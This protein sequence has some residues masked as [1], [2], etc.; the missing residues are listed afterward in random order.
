MKTRAAFTLLELLTIIGIISI[1]AA[2][3]LGAMFQSKVKAQK[4]QCANNLRQQGIALQQFTM[5][6]G[7]YPPDVNPAI[8]SEGRSWRAA[9]QSEIYNTVKI[10]SR[11]RSLWNCPSAAR[12]TSVDWESHEDWVYVDYGYNAYGLG[13][14]ASSNSLGLAKYWFNKQGNFI[15]VSRVGEAQVANPAEM[16]AIGDGFFGC[17]DAIKDGGGNF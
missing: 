8:W 6:N 13:S 5:D 1:G 15:S 16:Y 10:T 14:L 11:S 4:I 7:F 2:L 9:L 3:L 17:P 12:P